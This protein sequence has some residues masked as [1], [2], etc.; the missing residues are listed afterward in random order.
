[1]A[2]NP[3]RE[4]NTAPRGRSQ[5]ERVGVEGARMAGD[6]DELTAGEKQLINLQETLTL[7]E[8]PT[9]DRRLSPKADR[10][11]GSCDLPSEIGA[12]RLMRKLGSGGMGVV[13][14]AVDR[15][16]GRRVA[17]K[18]VKGHQPDAVP[19]F[20]REARVQGGIEHPNICPIYEALEFE[21]KPCIA[22]QY[23]DGRSLRDAAKLMTLDEKLALMVRVSHALHAAH[24]KGAVHRDVKPSNIMVEIG[25]D[26]VP[27]PY[28][29]D[30]GLAVEPGKDD[31]TVANVVVGT[32]A[33]MAPEQASGGRGSVDRRTDVYGLGAT[34]YH[35]LAGRPP[36]HGPS[37]LD[38]IV[39]VLGKE[40][41]LLS[42]YAPTIPRDLEIL[43]MKCLEKE[44]PRRYPSALEVARELQRYLDGEPI[45]AM[46]PSLGYKFWKKAR[47]NRLA[48]SVVGF[49]AL[50]TFM[51]LLWG[52]RTT[53]RSRQRVRLAAEMAREIERFESVNRA[54]RMMPTHDVRPDF[55]GVRSRMVE[56]NQGIETGRFPLQG[57]VYHAMARGWLVLGELP[58]AEE[59]VRKAWRSGYREPGVSM[60]RGLILGLRYLQEIETAERLALA[61][62]K[63]IIASSL[64]KAFREPALRYLEQGREAEESDGGISRILSSLLRGQYRQ[65]RQ[66]AAEELN[67]RPWAF[68]VVRVSGDAWLREAGS[69]PAH[70]RKKVAELQDLLEK[71]YEAYSR[72]TDLA[73]SDFASWEGRCDAA[74]RLFFF[75]G[76][77]GDR[78]VGDWGV[79]IRNDCS[80]A[81][82]ADPDRPLAY[83]VRARA[84]TLQGQWDAIDGR[85]PQ[86]SY[87]EALRLFSIARKKAPDDAYIR[88]QE[89]YLFQQVA[90]LK[91]ARGEDALDELARAIGALESSAERLGG[92][93]LVA[94]SLGWSLYQLGDERNKHGL[95]PDAAWKKSRLVLQKAVAMAPNDWR[96]FNNQGLVLTNIGYHYQ[97]RGQD[98]SREYDAALKSYKAGL[99]LQPESV[100]LWRKLAIL[101]RRYASWLTENGVD[102]RA[103][104]Q[105]S[106]S[107]MEK[108]LELDPS[109][110]LYYVDL[111]ELYNAMAI[112]DFL[113]GRSPLENLTKAVDYLAKSTKEDPFI[114]GGDKL[115]ATAWLIQAEFKLRRKQ[116]GSAELAQSISLWER[117]VKRDSLARAGLAKALLVRARATEKGRAHESFLDLKRVVRLAC[118]LVQENPVS[119]PGLLL[120]AEASMRLFLAGFPEGIHDAQAALERVFAVIPEQ[121]RARA[122]L[123]CLGTGA[124]FST[125]GTAPLMAN[126]VRQRYPRLDLDFGDCLLP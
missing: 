14:L 108:A 42:K 6:K 53:I 105:S 46:A 39:Q 71:A 80:M 117:M 83:T 3:K 112:A 69:D 32:P 76:N 13:Y 38:V 29:M 64:R 26:G 63:E 31:L 67:R 87:E 49:L 24:Q 22:M 95:D 21:G 74:S 25:D 58:K 77:L 9:A 79:T 124:L 126:E 123:G 2:Y 106:L 125:L 47:K 99:V 70:S 93:P 23:I 104:F 98:P 97:I 109:R 15:R 27:W 116:D 73:S 82:R 36:F 48:F 10:E 18:L 66:L 51:A 45:R 7:S 17:L 12:Y 4:K 75:L 84:L 85:D 111:A 115:R 35:L 54:I 33:Y 88:F 37:A 30:F 120:Q 81:V 56:L 102:A 50:A 60:T 89:A 28:V 92:I 5:V 41:V 72:A 8:V 61:E 62:E 121:A 11:A 114:P 86:A 94:M 16:L 101:H 20:L 100:M 57:P 110:T 90:Q 96:V 40:P 122:I 118:A 44:P 52:V 43:V 1:M 55:K 65:A 103:M 34:L 91:L 107:A 119:V 59:L 19:R 113:E 68:E 78:S